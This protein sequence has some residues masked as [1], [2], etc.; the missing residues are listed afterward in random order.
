MHYG[1]IAIGDLT[2][3]SCQQ[4]IKHAE[5]YLIREGKEV[6]KERLCINCCLGKGYAH[7]Q[8]DRGEEVLTFFGEQS[9]DSE[10]AP[11]KGS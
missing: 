6:S 4:T 11:E 9:P 3:D 7:H 1:C 2:C 8:K 10:S 5:R